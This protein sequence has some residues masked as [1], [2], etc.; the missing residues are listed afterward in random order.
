MPEKN[1]EI[2][3]DSSTAIRVYRNTISGRLVSFAVVLLNLHNG[4][5]V[6]I[7]RFDT[8]HGCPHRD[9]LGKKGGLLQKIWYDDLSSKE[10][11]ALAISI[12]ESN[13]EQIKRDYFA[14]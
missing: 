10:V 13:Y 12:F 5:W 1:F 3:I 7:Q 14:L 2:W 4:E 6:D 11:F 9:I 8:A